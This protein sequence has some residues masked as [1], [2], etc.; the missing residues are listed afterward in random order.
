MVDPGLD[1]YRETIAQSVVFEGLA[2]ADLDRILARC[3]ERGVDPGQVALREGHP[4]DGLS[5]I[6]E[7]RMEVLLL[8]QRV[9]GGRRPTPVRLNTLGPGRCFGE[10]SLL[11]DSPCSATVQAL[12]PTK[13]CFLPRVDFRRL[14]GEDDRVA[15]VVYGNL[16]RFLVGR[17]RGKDQELD[18]ILLTEPSES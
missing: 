4:G 3:Q 16:L 14:V 15:R 11:D 1:R 2:P 8:R 13:V 10:Y 7:G 18:M 5:V 12:V 6:L 17:L 9:K